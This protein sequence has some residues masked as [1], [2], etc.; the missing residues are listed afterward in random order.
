[1]VHSSSLLF[2]A[3]HS[4]L[5]HVINLVMQV[6]IS[7]YSKA[8]HFDPQNPKGHVP[9]SCNEVG[10]VRAIAVKVCI[11]YHCHSYC[12]LHTNC[13][14]E[15]IIFKV[16]RNMEDGSGQGRHCYTSPACP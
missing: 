1:M 12:S 6:L 5:A 15:T 9:T 2:I 14:S 7:T 13:I 4:C 16:K 10:L 3:S 11:M 8:P